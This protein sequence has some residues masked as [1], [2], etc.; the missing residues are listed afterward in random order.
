MYPPS[1][2]L[3]PSLSQA[4][5]NA[6]GYKMLHDAMA[7]CVCVCVCVFVCV[8]VCVFSY[9]QM[10]TYMYICTCM[11]AAGNALGYKMLHD[12]MAK[13]LAQ[14]RQRGAPA[15]AGAGTRAK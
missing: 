3:P 11:Q 12:A 8:C 15:G 7:V 5:G 13:R 4:A 10:Y 14:L 2:P 1:L 6:Q 9:T